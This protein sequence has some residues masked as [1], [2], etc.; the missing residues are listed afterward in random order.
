MDIPNTDL[1][2]LKGL[3]KKSVECLQSVGIFTRE[4]LMNVGPVAAFNRLTAAP[5]I[6]PSLNFL[7]AMVGALENRHWL[8]IAQNER[9]Q[10]LN[11]FDGYNEL[12]KIMV[13]EES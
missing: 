9:T 12:M 6:S 2:R 10:V 1:I 11:Q 13:S 8:D 5:G 3:G 7:Y 4:D